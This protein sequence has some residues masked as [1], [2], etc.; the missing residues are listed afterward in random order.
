MIKVV[1]RP[2]LGKEKYKEFRLCYV[3]SLSETV[4]YFYA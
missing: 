3:D 4:E 2:F 1:S